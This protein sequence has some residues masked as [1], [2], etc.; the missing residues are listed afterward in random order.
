MEISPNVITAGMQIPATFPVKNES[1][2]FSIANT[3]SFQRNYMSKVNHEIHMQKASVCS[4]FFHS[5]NLEK[6]RVPGPQLCLLLFLLCKDLYLQNQSLC[7]CQEIIGLYSCFCSLHT[8]HVLLHFLARFHHSCL[9]QHTLFNVYPLFHPCIQKNM[10]D[11]NPGEVLS[12]NSGFPLQRI[13]NPGLISKITWN[14]TPKLCS[15]KA[16]LNA[17]M[18]GACTPKGSNLAVSVHTPEG[19]P[20]KTRPSSLRPKITNCPL[21][22]QGSSICI[23]EFNKRRDRI[24][25]LGL[26]H[27]NIKCKCPRKSKYIPEPRQTQSEFNLPFEPVTDSCLRAQS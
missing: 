8:Y 2:F 15:V 26:C 14:G 7:F 17:S 10:Q 16:N 27:N 9:V 19:Q 25:S 23:L 11:R 20:I 4:I 5:V 24:L 13:R 18:P 12:C 1:L 21:R 6:L 3:Y 22:C